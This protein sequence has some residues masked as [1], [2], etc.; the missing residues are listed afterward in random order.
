MKRI[1]T[2]DIQKVAEDFNNG[3]VYTSAHVKNPDDLVKVFLPLNFLSKEQAQELVESAGLILEYKDTSSS[4]NKD[5]PVFIT[6]Q[7]VHVDD[8]LAFKAHCFGALH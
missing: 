5:M 3:L 1:A 2:S 8:M 6:A 7:Y 4:G